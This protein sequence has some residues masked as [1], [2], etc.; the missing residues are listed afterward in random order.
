MIKSKSIIGCVRHHWLIWSCLLFF[1]SIFGQAAEIKRPLNSNFLYTDSYAVMPGDSFE[2]TLNIF[3]EDLARGFQ[4]DISMPSGFTLDFPGVTEDPVLAPFSVSS[5]DLGSG[6]YRFVVFSLGSDVLP[7]GDY[8]VFYLPIT[9]SA[10]A[11]AGIYDFPLDNVTISGM[12]NQNIATPASIIGQVEIVG[13]S[14]PVAQN[15]SVTLSEDSQIDITLIA[16]DPEGDPLTYTIVTQPA[17]G[18]AVLTGNTVDYTPDADYNGPDSF[19]F[20]ANDGTTDSN[21]ATVS[22][23][24]TPV[25]DAPV[26]SDQSVTTDEDTVIQI[27][28]VATDVDGDPL[29]YAIVTQPTN[30]TAVLTGNTVDYTPDANYN[31]PDNFTFTANDGTTDSNVATVSI[32]VLLNINDLNAGSFS[33]RPNPFIS[34]VELD[35]VQEGSLVI[36]DLH[37][38]IIKNLPH[39]TVGKTDIVFENYPSGIFFIKFKSENNSEVIKLIKH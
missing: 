1:Q 22:I 38:Q 2:M 4:F 11:A 10:S 3:Q 21:L 14:P 39:C 32:D 31:G 37:G 13:N 12:N 9:V 36:Y 7:I 17:N 19:T 5:S 24:V 33:A 26:A 30:G 6:N 29:T 20:T 8:P 35:I 34:T 15:Q 28:L 16:T 27:T 23:D 18:T 25:N